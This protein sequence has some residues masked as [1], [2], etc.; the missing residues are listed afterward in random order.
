MSNIDA[1]NALITAINFDRFKEIEARHSPDV[2]FSSF[3]GPIIHSSVGVEDWQRTFLRD[4]ADCNYTELEYIDQDDTVA[5]R[6][7]IEAKGYDWRPF[8]QRVIEVFRLN[9]DEVLERRMY[10][11]L[12]DVEL[13]KPATAAMNAAL[14][15]RGG[16][17]SATK[18]LLADFYAAALAGDKETAATFLDDKAVLIDTVYGIASGPQ[19]ILDLRATIPR[20]VFGLERVTNSYAGAK[21]GC[22]E[23]AIDPS[24]PRLAEWVRVVD[25]KIKVIE[26]YWMLREI[27]VRPAMKWRHQRQVIMPI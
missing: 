22:V 4:Y 14:E 19:N 27:G 25:G 18:K 20:P 6:A 7:T 23:I 15:F 1:V 17:A 5:V 8:T 3:L 9:G 11:M 12:Q 24:R 16:S 21:D 13:D 10:A 26:S 2:V